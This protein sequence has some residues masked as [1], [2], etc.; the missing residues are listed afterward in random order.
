MKETIVLTGMVILAG[1]AMILDE[2]DI[3][4]MLVV[5][6]IAYIGGNHNGEK[7]NKALIESKP[8]NHSA[9]LEPI[10]T[11]EDKNWVR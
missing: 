6:L 9:T 8:G 4:L 10:G 2:I 3:C 5:A 1:I 7:R 11:T